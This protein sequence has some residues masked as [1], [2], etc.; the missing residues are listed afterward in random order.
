MKKTKPSRASSPRAKR[1]VPSIVLSATFVSAV[2]ACST[3]PSTTGDAGSQ[4]GVAD[5]GFHMPDAQF[6]VADAGFHAPDATLP[7]D[8]GGDA[9]SDASQ[10]G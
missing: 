10:N 8:G 5:S 7:D 3:P 4:Y 9:S 2:P 1:I 6:G